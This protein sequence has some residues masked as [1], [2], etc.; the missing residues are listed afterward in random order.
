M[1]RAVPIQA[2]VKSRCEFPWGRHIG[3]ALHTVRNMVGVFLMHAR[4][5]KGCEAVGRDLLVLRRGSRRRGHPQGNDGYR[6]DA[7][8]TDEI[9]IGG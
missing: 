6:D 1:Y 3:I 5:C 4:Q 9:M 8:P 7:L 2:S